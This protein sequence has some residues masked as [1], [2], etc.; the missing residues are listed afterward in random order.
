[1]VQ[2]IGATIFCGSY[3]LRSLHDVTG[4]SLV[5][6]ILIGLFLIFHL[7]LGI[8]AHRTAPSRLTKQAIFTYVYWIILIV[9]FIFAIFTNIEFTWTDGET[10]QLW[11]AIA[12]TFVVFLTMVI[13]R[14]N[15]SD[16][17]VKALFAIAY[18]SIPQILLAWKFLA[19][20]ATGTP[21]L[22]IFA[23]HFTIIIR[24]GQIYFMVKE[25]GLDRNRIWLA[26]S[27]SVNEL[28]WCVAT[29]AW[30]IVI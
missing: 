19:E 22:A 9:I 7:A 21:V 5:L 20:G 10:A 23:G 3:I 12:M 14:V 26:V 25:D 6:N 24:L 18:K 2:I 29:I 16:P 8:G 27:E 28:T 4:T 30:Y 11:T 15:L 13:R 1:V 17:M